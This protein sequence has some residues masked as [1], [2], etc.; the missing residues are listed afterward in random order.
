LQRCHG[1]T[2]TARKNSGIYKELAEDKGNDGKVK[3]SY[4]FNKVKA[5]PTP[6][7][8][9]SISDTFTS[10]IPTNLSSFYIPRSTIS[11]RKAI[12]LYYL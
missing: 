10:K 12:S 6:D 5:I 1:A 7:N 8:K 9:V 4:E 3:R 2:V 11:P